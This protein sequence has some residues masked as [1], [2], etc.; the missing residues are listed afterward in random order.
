MW[1]WLRLG[2]V[3]QRYLLIAAAATAVAGQ[4][5]DLV[6]SLVKRGAG[7]KDSSGILPGHGGLYDRIDALLLA[8]PVFVGALFFLGL[9]LDPV[10]PANLMPAR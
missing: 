5:G 7:V 3:D 9:V 8:A 6:E 10:E 1:S 2:H 4:L